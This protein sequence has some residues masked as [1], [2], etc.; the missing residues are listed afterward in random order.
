MRRLLILLA[1][2]GGSSNDAQQDAPPVVVDASPDAPVSDAWLDAYQ[3]RIV[4][5]L[6]GEEEISPGVRL[7]HRA[8]VAERN[9]TRDFLLDEFTALG[10][11]GRRHEYTTPTHM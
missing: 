7:A 3:R 6:S 9:A 2:C 1:A 4:A 11:T 8:S 5:A 10:L